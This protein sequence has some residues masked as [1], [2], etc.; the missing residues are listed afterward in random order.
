MIQKY[1][2][3]ILDDGFVVVAVHDKSSHKE[4]QEHNSAYEEIDITNFLKS[5]TK[6]SYHTELFKMRLLYCSYNSTVFI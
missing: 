6:F 4:V 2:Q 3:L 5:S 1:K